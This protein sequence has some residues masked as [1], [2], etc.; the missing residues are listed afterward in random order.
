MKNP[1]TQTA[2]SRKAS[3]AV[4][5]VFALVAL[6]GAM[7]ILTSPF[8]SPQ[9]VQPAN[10]VWADSAKVIQEKEVVEGDGSVLKVM[11]YTGLILLIIIIGARLYKKYSL[12]HNGQAVSQIKIV[13]RQALGP[14]QN[15]IVIVVENKKYL[16]GVT[17]QNINFLSDLGELGPEELREL[18]VTGQD[19][20]ANVIQRLRKQ[21][22][23]GSRGTQT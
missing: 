12:P 5:F 18:Q 4:A 17:E 23:Q 15:V 11:T 21:N 6:M 1:F 7:M 10:R 9:N 8:P 22:E 14:R 3:Y 2:T 19:N 16:I 20:F 13:A